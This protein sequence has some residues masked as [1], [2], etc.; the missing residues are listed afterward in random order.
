MI[1]RLIGIEDAM[2]KNECGNKSGK[3]NL[4]ATIPSKDYDTLKTTRECG[5]FQLFFIF[6]TWLSL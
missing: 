2:E 5:I 1:D 6:Y 3:E 4:K